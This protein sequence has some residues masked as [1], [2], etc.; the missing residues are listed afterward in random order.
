M[1]CAVLGKVGGAAIITDAVAAL[2]RHAV[3]GGAGAAVA[4]AAAGVASTAADV[5]CWYRGEGAAVAAA[6]LVRAAVLL[7]VLPEASVLGREG[8]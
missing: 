5:S 6:E 4:A 2:R 3:L 8:G 7:P 1:Q